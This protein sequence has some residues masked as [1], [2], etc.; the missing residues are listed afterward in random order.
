MK[1]KT[2]K[3]I[4]KIAADIPGMVTSHHSNGKAY[5]VPVNHYRRMKRAYIRNGLEGIKIYLDKV[6]KQ[7]AKSKPKA[8]P[9]VTGVKSAMVALM[10]CFCTF[11]NA[12]IEISTDSVIA[13]VSSQR[14]SSFV[15]GHGE[16]DRSTAPALWSKVGA[17]ESAHHFYINQRASM[18]MDHYDHKSDYYPIQYHS[19]Y[20]YLIRFI[21][22]DMVIDVNTSD[23]TVSYTWPMKGEKLIYK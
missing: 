21:H 6:Q 12:Q 8:E 19:S 16:G 1:K 18:L 17:K 9:K 14:D 11:L 7:I 10:I 20:D 23:G 22:Q 2:C 5:K 15:I 3:S 13:Y 4:R